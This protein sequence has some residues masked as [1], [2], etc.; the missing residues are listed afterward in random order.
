MV[1]ADKNGMLSA[2]V[3]NLVVLSVLAWAALA[4]AYPDFYYQ[5]VQE[6]GVLEWMTFWAFL[7][8]AAAY[9]R[10]ALLS[11][12]AGVGLPWFEAS[13]ALFCFFVAMEEISWAQRLFGYRAPEYFLEHNFQQELNVHNVFDTS[14]RKY[15]LKT[16]ILGFGVALPLLALVPAASRLLDRMGI[17][18]PSRWLLPAFIGTF[19][20]YQA[21]PWK[22]SGELTELMLGGCF[23]F[24]AIG[25]GGFQRNESAGSRDW[26]RIA[27]GAAL[28]AALGY[29]NTEI[30][31]ALMRTD[32]AALEAAR[33][34]SMTKELGH[35]VLASRDFASSA[36]D[37][38]TSLGEHR[39]KGVG[40]PFE[41][42]AMARKAAGK[43]AE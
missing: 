2:L 33:I 13:L 19:W 10:S 8:A 17:Q 37:A 30:F 31:R 18:A 15:A 7:L 28:V 32:P 36:P 12:R 11:R 4:Q 34:E 26:V 20:T 14:L 41:I 16:V 29:G 21:Y 39:L 24:A 23:L 22:F 5:S 25:F 3:A 27:A 42:F 35:D 1:D 9:L 40:E 38:W 6:D 43:D